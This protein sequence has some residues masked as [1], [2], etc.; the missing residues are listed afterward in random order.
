VNVVMRHVQTAG[1]HGLLLKR[2]VVADTDSLVVG[3]ALNSV[4]GLI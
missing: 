2:P 4:F 1:S 3:R